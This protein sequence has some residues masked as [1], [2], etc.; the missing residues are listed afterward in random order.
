M[1]IYLIVKPIPY[2]FIKESY[3]KKGASWIVDICI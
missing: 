2:D 3:K 1:G